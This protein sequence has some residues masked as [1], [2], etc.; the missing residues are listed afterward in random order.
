MRTKSVL[1]V[2]LCLASAGWSEVELPEGIAFEPYDLPSLDS[3]VLRTTVVR[4]YSPASPDDVVML[5]LLQSRYGTEV[6]ALADDN[7]SIRI[8]A[9][10]GYIVFVDSAGLDVAMSMNSDLFTGQRMSTEARRSYDG[11][12]KLARE[13]VVDANPDGSIERDTTTFVWRREACA[14]EQD[15]T[16]SREW[17]VDAGGRCVEAAVRYRLDDGT[18]GAVSERH[19]IVWNGSRIQRA[20]TIDLAGDTIARDEYSYLADGRI[21]SVVC[22]TMVEG[23]RLQ[24]MVRTYEWNGDEIVRILM[25]Q[26][27]EEGTVESIIE[28]PVPRVGVAPQVRKLSELEVRHIDGAML[29][30]NT[31]KD[32][33]E[34][35]MTDPQGKVVGYLAVPSSGTGRWIAPPS[36]RVVAWVARSPSGVSS[37]RSLLAR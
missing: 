6:V 22:S 25:V 20:L 2:L 35:T 23:D 13:I 16:R 10:E 37:G 8:A 11:S 27:Q 33:I 18:W 28:N 17:S 32:P 1:G 5:Q 7:A 26:V 14:D 19:L 15:A 29:F 31:S 12:G 3:L 21:A 9:S 34:V 4:P 24:E 36:T 30:A